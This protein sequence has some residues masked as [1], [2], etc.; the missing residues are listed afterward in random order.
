MGRIAETNLEESVAVKP[1]H[2]KLGLKKNFSWVFVSTTYLSLTRWLMISCLAKLGAPADVGMWTVAQAICLPVLWFSSLNLRAVMV[3]DAKSRFHYG[4]Y[5]AMRLT[6]AAAALAI[7]A[8]IAVCGGYDQFTRLVIIVFGAGS[9][10]FS[11]REIILAIMIKNECM[12]ISSRSEIMLGTVSLGGFAL[13]LYLTGSF[14]TALIVL[15]AGRMAIMLLHDV[16]FAR[17]VAKT[18]SDTESQASLKPDWSVR[19][20]FP[21]CVTALPLGMAM[22]FSSLNNS[23][24]IYFLE[25]YHGKDVTGYFGAIAS[26]VTASMLLMN[27]LG[28]A[29][30][31]R[32]AKYFVENRRAFKA[33]V[34]KLMIIGTFGGVL[35]VCVAHLLGRQI[36]TLAFTA[37]YARHSRDFVWLIAGGGVM[38]VVSFL[39]YAIIAA[40]AFIHLLVSYVVIATVTLGLSAWRIPNGGLAG[41]VWVRLASAGVAL[42][43]LAGALTLILKQKPAASTEPARQSTV[44][45]EGGQEP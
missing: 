4:Q 14:I 44:A 26:I 16:P 27:T 15:V 42:V 29:V 12:N 9:V 28:T 10:M 35:A 22:T 30:N 23:I 41:T 21:L 20:L 39:I 45:T 25:R 13:T 38:F 2:R 33:L 18:F 36:L 43:V 1:K 40:R 37:E 11:V 24:P 5:I 7:I 31:P 3:T 19:S 8:G 34:A 6:T 32:L 17:S